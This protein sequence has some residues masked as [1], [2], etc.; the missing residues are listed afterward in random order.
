MF[1]QLHITCIIPA[2]NEAEAIGT[3]VQELLAQQD[4]DGT[5]LIDQIIVAD[6]G[7][8]DHTGK[9]AREAGAIVVSET[10]RGYGAACLAAMNSLTKTDVVLFVDGDC[11]V[12]VSQT[13]R[14]LS[15]IEA[16]A[17]MAIGSRCSG[18]IEP[19][20]MSWP[21]RFG[22]ALI[23][24]IVSIVWQTRVTD[25]GPFRAIRYSAL[26]ALAMQDQAYGWTVEMQ[27][28]ALQQGMVVKEV[29]VDCLVRVGRSKVSGTIR[30]VIGAACGMLGMIARLW[31]QGRQ[32]KKCHSLAS[33]NCLSEKG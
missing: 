33:L 20:S 31:W 22:N 1:K 13:S 17:D 8:V 18:Y 24:R 25:I 12:R 10:R 2:L 28:K 3:V 27:V 9:V 14:L 30:G 11:S 7:S 23:A 16:G 15:A 29:P 21:Q 19:G 5:R 26:Q 6:N 4:C 32:R